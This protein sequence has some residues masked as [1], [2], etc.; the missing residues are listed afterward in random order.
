MF[1]V[2][3]VEV[4]ALSLVGV[5]RGVTE[6]ISIGVVPSVVIVPVKSLFVIY[7]VNENL[8]LPLVL[9]KGGETLYK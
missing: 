1:V 3:R 7:S 8:V 9:L 4:S 6:H 2:K 5:S